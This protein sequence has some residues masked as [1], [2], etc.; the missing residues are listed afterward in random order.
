[1]IFAESQ[2]SAEHNLRNAA[3]YFTPSLYNIHND[4]SLIKTNNKYYERA[5]LVNIESKLSGEVLGK[6]VLK[7][8]T[9]L[10]LVLKNCVGVSTDGCSVMSSKICGA[11]VNYS[12]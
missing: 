5:W 7:I 2:G 4:R 11:I 8:M 1:V 12:K 10:G 3:L 9:R 6:T